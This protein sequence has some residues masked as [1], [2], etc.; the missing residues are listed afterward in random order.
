MKLTV[1]QADKGDCL[2]VTSGSGGHRILVDGGMS[3]SYSTHVAPKLGALAKAGKKLDLVYVSHI[4]QDHIAGVLKLLDDV[5]DWRVFDHHEENGNPINKKPE[6]PRPPEIGSIWHNAFHEQL[7]DNAG[8]IEDMLAASASILSAIANE[9]PRVDALAASQASLATS[10]REAIR[11]SRRIS[12]KQLNIPLNPEFDGGLMFVLDEQ[13]EIRFG[14]M[15]AHILGPFKEDLEKLRR[16]WNKWLEE[17]QKV[18][19]EIA[20]KA[21]EDEDRLTSEAARVVEP[22]IAQARELGNRENVTTPNLASLM[23]LLEERGRTVLLTGDGHWEDILAGLDHNGKLTNG[24]IHVDVL[25]VQHHGS[26]HNIHAD[27]CQAVTADSYVFCGNGAHEN[28]DLEV[29][30][31]IAESRLRESDSRPFRFWFNSSSRASEIPANAAHMRKVEE[32]VG[33]L[34]RRS[35]R[36]MTAKFLKNESSFD[37]EVAAAVAATGG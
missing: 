18:L 23:V 30:K 19:R 1:F 16:D 3:S 12:P 13:P 7:G 29:M 26:E 15:R 8:P 9:S 33:K 14:D 36:R 10:I 21:R 27:F 31:L 24:R 32:L 35:A 22:L 37:L 17:T 11:V 20:K 25:K 6:N 34:T 28:P 5:V 2:L 4:D